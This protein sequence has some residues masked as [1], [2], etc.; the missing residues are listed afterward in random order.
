LAHLEDWTE[1]RQD[2]AECYRTLF[3][4]Y[5]LASRIKIPSPPPD[6]SH[7][8]N[9]FVIRCTERDSVREFLLNHG[10]PTE[11]YYP[12]PLHLQPAFAYLE[13]KPGQLPEAESASREVLALPIYPEL[14]RENQI[15][16]VRTIAEFYAKDR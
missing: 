11:I 1:S 14:S 15:M 7:V 10:I 3:Q 16:V 12:S 2:K 8:Y 5:G 6:R 4:D 13:C 9:Q